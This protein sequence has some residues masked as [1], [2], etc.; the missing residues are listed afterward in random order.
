MRKS[1]ITG[2]LGAAAL[3][4]GGIGPVGA[5]PTGTGPVGAEVPEF[6]RGTAHSAF[7]FPLEAG[8]N[9]SMHTMTVKPGEAVGW[10]PGAGSAMVVVKAGALTNYPTCQTKETWSAGGVY[11]RTTTGSDAA[12]ATVNEGSGPA[13]LVVISSDAAGS[14]APAAA[15]HSQHGAMALPV[16]EGGSHEQPAAQAAGCPAGA[17][18]QSTEH[19]HGMAYG[20]GELKQEAGKQVVVEL[21]RLAPGYTSDWHQHPD[22]N[23]A[24]QTKGVIEN[25][26]SCKDKEVWYPDNAYFHAP[27]HHGNHPNLTNNKTD[28]PAELIAIFFNVPSGHPAPVTPIM[29][30]PPPAECP[31]SALTY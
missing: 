13:E 19:G 9:V 20:P 22:A 21:F 17:A 24:I 3:L 15:G 6:G 12:G 10:R 5:V 7:T 18:G 11:F 2:S 29:K 26:T 4:A 31:T 1:W 28:K 25:W 8:Q 23:L 16:M 27:G 30:A 14:P